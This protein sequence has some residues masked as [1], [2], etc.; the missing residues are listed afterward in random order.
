MAEESVPLGPH[1]VPGGALPRGLSSS[2]LEEHE[3]SQ[4]QYGENLN[5]QGQANNPFLQQ[6]QQAEDYSYTA[7]GRYDAHL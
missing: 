7:D 2:K 5:V 3:A 1:G 6:D 4:E